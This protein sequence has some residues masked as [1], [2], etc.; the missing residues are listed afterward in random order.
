MKNIYPVLLLLFLFMLEASATSLKFGGLLR[1]KL[2]EWTENP[3]AVEFEVENDSNFAANQY[4]VDV[5]IKDWNAQ[6]V[7][8]ETV[9]GGN[10]P[11]YESQ[12]LKTMGE[13][14]P[15]MPGTYSLEMQINFDQEVDPSDNNLE[16]EFE[17]TDPPGFILNAGYGLSFHQINFTYSNLQEQI[18]GFLL[19][20]MDFAAIYEV[21]NITS[22]YLNVF[23]PQLGWVVQN[24]IYDYN[25]GYPGLSTMLF[26]GMEG[27]ITGFDATAIISEEPFH[28]IIDS[29]VFET[30]E[31][32]LIDY[33]AQGRNA[34]IGTI[35]APIPFDSIEFKED[36]RRDLVWQHGHVNVEQDENQCAPMSVANSLQ[37]LENEHGLPV[38]HEHKPGIRDT[39]LVG[40]IDKAMNRDEHDPVG[41]TD[42]LEGKIK[43]IDD[44]NLTDSLKIKHKNRNGTN[45]VSNDTVTVGN[46]SSIPNTDTTS[47]IDWILQELKD[48]E[49]VELAIGWEG[50]G[51]HW[52]DLIGG[53]YVDG[54]PWLAWVHD[55]NQGYDDMGTAGDETDDTTTNN[56]GI[57]P[58]T[59]GYGWSY[60]IDNKLVSVVGEDTSRGTIDL[61]FSESRD[62][63]MV[64]SVTEDYDDALINKFSLE[65]NYPNP[66][67]PMTT[68]KFNLPKDSNV[69]LK[70]YDILGNQVRILS[71]GYK[72]AGSY[73]I[74]FRADNLA[75]G[76]YIYEIR[77]DDFFDTKKM[78]LIK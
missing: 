2:T 77:A 8:E 9:E 55:A 3:F 50:G 19:A 24:M 39:S 12:T 14:F 53:G 25:S 28:S 32:S 40:E 61:A 13:F 68:I 42:A 34:P 74:E 59:G 30:F 72:K 7:F 18:S 27:P 69:K 65:Q 58:Q 4:S 49:D 41:D 23:N 63:M 75:S 44:N 16:M 52:V 66:F 37:W 35:P 31:V 51:G 11:Q 47:L 64:T 71:S 43:Y 38:P 22:G 36:G 62:T 26:S 21:T 78:V 17:V 73:K 60:I 54:V 10:L 76:V 33:N 6:I 15:E 56:G 67:N 45:F 1:P 20:A 46:T 70:V 5:Y 57:T 48:D 29:P